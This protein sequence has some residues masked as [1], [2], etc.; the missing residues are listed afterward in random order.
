M[1]IKIA[2]TLIIFSTII[3]YCDTTTTYHWPIPNV[4]PKVISNF[5]D[6]RPLSTYANPHFHEGIDIPATTADVR[7]VTNNFILCEL[8][9][10]EYYGWVVKLQHCT[11][12][13]SAAFW[14]GSRYIHMSDVNDTLD[15][16]DV[17]YSGVYVSHQTTF[18]HNHLHFNFHRPDPLTGSTRINPFFKSEFRPPS[19]NYSPVLHNLYVDYTHHGNADVENFNFLSYDFGNLYKD[20]LLYGWSFKKLKLP[21]ETKDNDLDDPHI[22][23]SG[24][25]KVKFVVEA[26]DNI[27][28]SN[29]TA[30]VYILKLYLDLAI[31]FASIKPCY[32]LKFDTL[33]E[34]E[35]YQVGDVYLNSQLGMPQLYRLYP[36]DSLHNG[37]PGCVITDTMIVDTLSLK[38]ENLD[39][40]LHRIRIYAQDYHNNTKTADVH[41]Y[42]RKSNWVDFCRG[43]QE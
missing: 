40:G 33:L 30:T 21:E 35:K 3:G 36:Y 24:N 10:S 7:C 4:N 12:D 39:E 5:C 34:S 28:H 13:T 18:W 17:V 23:V 20:T 32:A 11:D 31:F 27:N 38:T 37:L 16:I 26:H 1:M 15:T 41:F 9:D 19:D 25:R 2:I 14:H 22:L 29:D 6:Y 43:F 8:P 42:I